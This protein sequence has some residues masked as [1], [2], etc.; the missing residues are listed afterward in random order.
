[1]FERVEALHVILVAPNLTTLGGYEL[2]L[3]VLAEGLAAAGHRPQVF[4]RSS[5]ASDHPY[6]AR[7]L[8]AQVEV[9]APPAW[10]ERCLDW[11]LSLR[12]AVE[13][14]AL[15]LVAP[16]LALVSLLDTGLRRRRPSRSW[17]GA[18]GRWRRVVHPISRFDA[19]SWWLWRRL[20]RSIRHARPDL[21]DV[22]H[23]MIPEAIAY[24]RNRGLPVVYTE[25]GAP[26][27]NMASVWLG[28]CPYVNMV[29]G[30]IGR[31]EA[32]FLG[33]ERL[34]GLRAEIPRAIV[35]NAVR[36]PREQEAVS[37]AVDADGTVAIT[38]IGRLVPS[39]GC[40]DLLEAFHKLITAGLDVQLV[41]AG[42]G[43]LRG[44]LEARVQ[45][46]GLRDR[47]TFTGR[48][49]SL[50]PIIRRTQIVAHPTLNDGRSVA[51]L[52]AMAWSRPVVGTRVGGVEE[53]IDDGESGLLVPAED[54]TALAAALRRLV[55]EPALRARM[56]AAARTAFER[57]GYTQEDMVAG[58][59]RHYRAISATRAYPP[60]NV[61]RT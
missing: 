29:D 57:G 9:D 52:E 8:A 15:L 37:G 2:Q 55:R 49:G 23:S 28:L 25:Y 54:P 41:F 16:M 34:C 5:V 4:F 59:V 14:V 6:L 10:L 12:R 33:L 43:E 22:Q 11:R 7:M 36:G 19:L 50:E 30:L 35:P 13:Q 18:L 20:D 24:A 60:M 31:A 17:R 46:L 38:S 56:G 47:V 48:F 51:V 53:L 58:T 21:V 1:M 40:W 45:A 42:D 27:T 32:S 26:S 3:S 39:K 61:G 44:D